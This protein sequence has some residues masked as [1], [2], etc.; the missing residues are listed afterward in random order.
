MSLSTIK[1]KSLWSFSLI[2]NTSTTVPVFSIVLREN[3]YF[4]YLTTLSS[5]PVSMCLLFAILVN[6]SDHCN[7][8]YHLNFTIWS[9]I[10]LWILFLHLCMF[11]EH[12]NVINNLLLFKIYLCF[13]L[14]NCVITIVIMFTNYEKKLHNSPKY[15]A[16]MKYKTSD[17]AVYQIIAWI[18]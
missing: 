12:L 14:S 13:F 15:M 6:I 2:R 11:C 1:F 17:W 5:I 18:N 8:H 16:H 3:W 7:Q 10:L 4:W 9:H